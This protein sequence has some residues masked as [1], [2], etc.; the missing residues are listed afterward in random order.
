M[1][2]R[3]DRDRQIV[4]PVELLEFRQL[5]RNRLLG[6]VFSGEGIGCLQTVAGDTQHGG[7]VWQD[8][9]ALDEL[10]G[11]AQGHTP[12]GFSEDALAFSK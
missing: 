9:I 3:S 6:F 8:A 12:G 4:F 1:Q 11:A 7:L 10:A 2:L 5:C